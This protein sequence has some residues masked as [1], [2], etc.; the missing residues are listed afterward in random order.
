LKKGVGGMLQ[1]VDKNGK[2]LKSDNF[3]DA[4]DFVVQLKDVRLFKP[5]EVFIEYSYG[6]YILISEIARFETI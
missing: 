4:N 2:T 1:I 3:V 5:D 6:K